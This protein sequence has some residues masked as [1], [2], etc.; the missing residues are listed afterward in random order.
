[1]TT[2]VQLQAV[3]DRVQTGC[4]TALVTIDAPDDRAE[5]GYWFLDIKHA[6]RHVVVDWRAAVGYGVTLLREEHF[7]GEGAD[8]GFEAAEPTAKRVIALLG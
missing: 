2:P 8:E 5:T 3:I 4:P 1:M 7:Y 6:G